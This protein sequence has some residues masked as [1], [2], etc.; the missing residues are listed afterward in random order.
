MEKNIFK[1]F[2]N[3]RVYKIARLN[4]SERMKKTKQTDIDQ[5]LDN[6]DINEPTFKDLN[7][8]KA[9]LSASP[10]AIKEE[11]PKVSSKKKSKT[12]KRDHNWTLY[13]ILISILIIA[14]KYII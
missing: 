5:I 13:L 8:A 6:F 9:F 7:E 14:W 12:K 10:Q 3:E 2:L 1:N 4:L 11:I